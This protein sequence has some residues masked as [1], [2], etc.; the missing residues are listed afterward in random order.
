M[1]RPRGTGKFCRA[2]ILV[3]SPTLLGIKS[4]TRSGILEIPNNMD[5][6][7][8]KYNADFVGVRI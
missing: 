2:A 5:I 3:P 7:G 8:V 6:A 4:K 1:V